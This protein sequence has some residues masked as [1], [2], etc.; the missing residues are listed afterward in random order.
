MH[1][2]NS[3]FVKPNVTRVVC[4]IALVGTSGLGLPT[5]FAGRGVDCTRKS[6]PVELDTL[7]LKLVPDRSAYQRGSRVKVTVTVTRFGP[8]GSAAAQLGGSAPLAFALVE[9]TLVS[10]NSAVAYAGQETNT[11]GRALLLFSISKNAPIGPL[12]I[13]A[14]V[15]YVTVD[16]LDCTGPIVVETGHAQQSRFI[17]VAP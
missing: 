16:S 6:A 11:E 8:D 15:R 3:P 2:Q 1:A 14:G 12:D 4:V 9:S 10:G 13:D 17:T 5:A 7:Y